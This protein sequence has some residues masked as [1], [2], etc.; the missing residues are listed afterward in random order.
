MP[1]KNSGRKNC[2]LV[3]IFKQQP[4][5]KK[6]TG[7]LLGYLG[8][9]CNI[10]TEDY[11]DFQNFDEFEINGSKNSKKE[12]H[13]ENNISTYVSFIQNMIDHDIFHYLKSCLSSYGKPN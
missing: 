2:I 13:S 4:N 11:K 12:Q 1:P 8:F 9:I 6:A 10:P 7:V 5:I 3:R